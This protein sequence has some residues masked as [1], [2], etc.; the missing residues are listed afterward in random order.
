MMHGLILSQ[1]ERVQPSGHK[2]L[3]P[4]RGRQQQVRRQK[5]KVSLQ[6]HDEREYELIE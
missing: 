6:L 4:A 3:L 2:K 5:I 1:R